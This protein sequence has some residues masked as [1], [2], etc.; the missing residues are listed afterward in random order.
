VIRA[1]LETEIREEDMAIGNPFGWGSDQLGH[2]ASA[3]MSTIHAIHRPKES[4]RAPLPAVR[5]IELADI[6]DALTKGFQDFAACRTDVLFMCGV[7]PVMGL[8]LARLVI[9]QG[10]FQMLFPIAS[11][12]ALIGPFVGLG[13]YEMSR[14][15]EQGATVNWATAFQ[16]LRSPSASAIA[17]LGLL[18]TAIFLAWLFI[19]QNI[20]D[21]TLGPYLP[22][23][24]TTFAHDIVTTPLGWILMGAGIGIG[25][26]F[27]V[28][29]FAISVVSFPLL[30][31]RDDIGIDVAIGTSI[32]AV[33]ANP[34]VMAVWAMIIAGSLVIGSI[35]F[36]VGL[37][38]VLPILG[39]A[40]WH[41]Y[42]RLVSR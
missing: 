32:R 41:L 37:V 30:L 10:L 24:I 17:G 5:R 26:V 21:M 28:I 11:G 31:D 27:A 8:V 34:W 16:V 14:Q 22:A 19:A 23:S 7:Y 20:Y 40:T 42:R 12:F 3:V 25:F 9:G 6:K 39:H 18:L 15:R 13:L 1:S 29:V 33:I 35:P 2:A 38:L 4:L 36:F